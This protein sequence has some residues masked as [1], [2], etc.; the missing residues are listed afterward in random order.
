MTRIRTIEFISGLFI[1]LFL[2]TAV[3]KFR[4]FSGFVGDMHN[5]PLPYFASTVLAWTL[6][7]I[8]VSIAVLLMFDRT[9]I[10]GLK[11][12]LVIMLVFTVYTALV[13]FHFFNRIPCSCGG[14]IKSLSWKQH[15]FFNLFF[16]SLAYLGIALSKKQNNKKAI[17]IA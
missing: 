1:L 2:Y 3:S 16:V 12:S 9:R 5:Q 6:P 7:P 13:L 10:T 17:S 4:D 8:E 11:A 15:L 14:I